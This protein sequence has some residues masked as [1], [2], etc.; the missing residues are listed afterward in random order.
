MGYSKTVFL[1]G[2]RSAV[3]FPELLMLLFHLG[4][5]L[6]DCVSLY[7]SLGSFIPSLS[8]EKKQ[9]PQGREEV[10]TKPGRKEKNY[11]LL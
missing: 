4:L 7:P 11:P 8:L 3:F 10:K 6:K 2:N 5:S 9:Y 1:R